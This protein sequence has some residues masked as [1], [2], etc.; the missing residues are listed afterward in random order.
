MINLHE[1]MLPTS[2]GVEP[3]TS[4]SP[5]GRRI[6]L[7]HRGRPEQYTSAELKIWY[8]L[9]N[10][11]MQVKIP[12]DYYLKYVFLIFPR[13]EPLTFQAKCL[14]RREFTHSQVL[15]KAKQNEKKKRKKNDT[16]FL[17]IFVFAVVAHI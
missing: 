12:S 15:I 10:L 13:K 1:R 14:L 16:Y 17:G 6:Q 9:Y 8:N 5:V 2:A 3:A 4:W 11:F 7:S